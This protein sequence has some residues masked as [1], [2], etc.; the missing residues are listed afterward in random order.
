[1]VKLHFVHFQMVLKLG[2]L[3]LY[4]QWIGFFR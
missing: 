2:P 1:M 3:H 4:I